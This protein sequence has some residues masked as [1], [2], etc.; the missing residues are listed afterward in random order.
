MNWL[1]SISWYTM[2]DGSHAPSAQTLPK[3][4]KI[5]A[6]LILFLLLRQHYCMI[7]SDS[8]LLARVNRDTP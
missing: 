8:K 2:K 6:L 7:I 1:S 5:T 4:I 3:T